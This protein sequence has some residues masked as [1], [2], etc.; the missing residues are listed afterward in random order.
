MLSSYASNSVLTKTR[1]KFG[2]MLKSDD[3]K[4]LVAM[5]SVSDIAAYL[6]S[7]T[8]YRDVL[9]NVNES[10]I[11]RGNLEFLLRSQLLSDFAELCN[12]EKSVGN[13]FF[14]FITAYGE[15]NELL[16]FIRYFNAGQPE[17]Y[18]LNMP[19]FFDKHT[20]LDL[21]AMSQVKTYSQLVEFLNHSPYQKLLSPF[22]VKDGEPLDILNIEAEL[23]KYLYKL[24][25]KLIDSS[26]H[27]G[28][29]D[30]INIYK[31]NAELDNIRRIYRGKKYF[32]LSKEVIISQMLPYQ[33]KISKRQLDK[34]LSADKP[35]EVLEIVKQAYRSKYCDFSSSNI[36]MNC[37]IIFYKY[38][39][40]KLRYT[41]YSSVAMACYFYLFDYEIK[42]ITTIIE[43]A[44]YKVPFDEYK[45]LILFYS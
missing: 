5:S 39:S 19:D 38:I 4:A 34:M 13:H 17:K 31:M 22:E 30:L 29:E 33:Y 6:K 45:D 18:L 41:K 2:K 14:E 1:S 16:R 9:K 20:P 23:Y 25:F 27:A 42:D 10:A 8:H 35:D 12:F 44:R 7:N 21:V 11:H 24:L 36:D 3:Y 43:G 26:L 40:K 32:G 37:Y 28:K 15:V